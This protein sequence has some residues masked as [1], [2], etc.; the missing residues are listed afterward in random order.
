[1]KF[2]PLARLA[3]RRPC[4][5]RRDALLRLLPRG[6]GRTAEA[7]CRRLAR[8]R[9]DD[10]RE[11]RNG[12]LPPVDERGQRGQDQ[13]RGRCTLAGTT[14]SINGTIAFISGHFEAAMTSNASFTGTAIGRKKGDTIVFD[15]KE[16]QKGDDGNDM[17]V[18]AEHGA[19]R[20]Q[21]QRQLQGRLPQDR[22]QHRRAGAV[23]QVI[24]ATAGTKQKGGHGPPFAFLAAPSARSERDVVVHAAGL[25]RRRARGD[26]R[27]PCGRRL[28]AALSR[29]AGEAA[30]LRPRRRRARRASSGSS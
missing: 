28:P 27:R 11:H 1:M 29:G 26:G 21:D 18:S 16:K 9:H 24:P 7:V 10:R 13:L 17:D 12:R 4:W 23:Q 5:S 15:L 19:R 25:E 30:L 3:C 6:R 2:S 20:R 22:R 8:P 14:L